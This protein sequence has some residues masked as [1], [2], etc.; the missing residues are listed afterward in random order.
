MTSQQLVQR[1]RDAFVELNTTYDAMVD[2]DMDMKQIRGWLREW[3]DIKDRQA[4]D[5]LVQA[6]ND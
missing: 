3:L 1:F 2:A 6:A 5:A 4:V